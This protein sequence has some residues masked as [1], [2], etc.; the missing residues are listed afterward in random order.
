[1]RCLDDTTI[2]LLVEGRLASDAL[3][4]ID[5]HLDE[6]PSCR[7]KVAACARRSES[8]PASDLPSPE[9]TRSERHDLEP[10]S[11]PFV[12]RL[13]GGRYRVVKKLGGGGMGSVYEA[14]HVLIGRRVA[15]KLLHPQYASNRDVVRRFQNEARAAATLGHPNILEALD[16]GRT[17]DGLPFL[18]LELLEGH[19]LDHEIVERGAMPIDR[20]VIIALEIADALSAAHAAG[21]VHR[22]LK[23]ENVFLTNDG[24]VKVL[25]FGIS[26]I[27][28]SL[29]TGGLTAPGQMMGTPQYMAPEQ[30]EDASKADPRSDVYAL[31]VLLYR[32]LTGALPFSAPSL[33]QLLMKIVSTVPT[34]VAELRRDCPID[35]SDIVSR[36]MAS[37]AGARFASM[38][39]LARAIAPF[40]ATRS[41]IAPPSARGKER[42]VVTVLVASGV[43]DRDRA[44]SAI[45]AAGGRVEELSSGELLGLFGEETWQGDEVSR[46]LDAA[47]AVRG[48]TN[49]TAVSLGH[50]T[51]AG[52]APEGEPIDRALT[53]CDAGLAGVGLV[54][55]GREPRGAFVTRRVTS[56]LVEV[57]ARAAPAFSIFPTLH[58]ESQPLLGREAEVAQLRA[59]M[60]RV[61]EGRQ[62][63]IV[64]VSGPSGMGKTRLA[65]ELV[66]LV[67]PEGFSLLVARAR[68]GPAPRIG[69]FSGAI[70]SRAR[71][72]TRTANAPRIDADAPM[73]ERRRAVARLSAEASPE[74]SGELAQFL[75][76]LVGVPMPAST[77]LHAARG[78][79]RL[80]A[81]RLE[82]AIR[83][84]VGGLAAQAPLAIV[85]EDLQWADA[86]SLSLL[87]E[88]VDASWDL[89]ILVVGT[90]RD[91][92][93]PEPQALFARHD[94]TE[95]KLQGLRLPD[96]KALA[97]WIGGVEI[98]DALARALVERTSGTPFF[99]E[100][101]LDALVESAALGDPPDE[102]PLP[103]DVE[104]AVQARLDALDVE[105]KDVL[106]RA[107]VLGRVFS[108]EDLRVLGVED[109]ERRL[110]SLARR[111]FLR[112]RATR[113]RAG[114]TEY[115]MRTSLVADVVYR[116]LT[117]D[118]RRALHL[119]AARML[120]KQSTSEPEVVALHFERAGFADEAAK[121]FARAAL[122]AERRKDTDKVLRCAARALALGAP[123]EYRFALAM[124][125][126]DALE[127]E[128]RLDEQGPALEDAL[129]LARS[130][131]E[132]ARAL[133]AHGIH[134]L[135]TGAPA[136]A[137]PIFEEA[138]R[139]GST[140]GDPAAE[141][142]ALGRLATALVYAGRLDEARGTLA[143]AER[144]VMTRAPQLGAD[145][146]T[147]RAQLAGAEGDLGA[148]R[149]AYW[150][151]VELYTQAGD[152][153]SAAGAS[154]NLADAFNRVGAHAEAEQALREA[155]D[156]CR[157][158]R[159]G[160]MEG[161]GWLNLGYALTM[162]D[163]HGEAAEALGRAIDVAR[164]SKDARLG[165][166]AELYRARLFVRTGELDAAR[167]AALRTLDEATHLGIEAIAILARVI[168]ALAI[169]GLGDAPR[170]LALTTEA[171]RARGTLGGLE[172]DE[173]EL[174]A[175][176]VLALEANGRRDEAR[177]VREQGARLVRTAA[178]RIGDPAWRDR[179]LRDVPAHR[180]LL[181]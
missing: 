138:V 176:H 81:D 115:E 152:L 16:M 155:L 50:V 79:P 71:F 172:E 131:E 166:F 45:E 133:T 119:D 72:A 29:V 34:P 94:V 170:A 8:L 97:Q 24:R 106:K 99:L 61:V 104:A 130:P 18:V 69:L 107:S 132:R 175:A 149:S 57:S 2:D 168:A 55:F 15:L 68:P 159:V 58:A 66:R 157:R 181:G 41:S 161:Y 160:L 171:M 136:L 43:R 54:G 102:L 60:A 164:A 125:A 128:G 110:D 140:S 13:V 173:G 154:V 83:D 26:K 165:L 100:Q 87:E 120:A 114:A 17:E 1:M 74:D 143:N 129:A 53:A 103:I 48:V 3:P 14:E 75:G 96:V 88:I 65:A 117:D 40:R 6:C 169:L 9:P 22:D 31:G 137:I 10:M 148:R 49:A 33:P 89:P 144:L 158:L 5:L 121:A 67:E 142:R 162:L 77:P 127:A 92:L 27:T 116:L 112:R 108:S 147:W 179:F 98:S 59:T 44:T 20:A 151:A 19:D 124:A 7:R 82:L 167:D 134:V 113:E 91:D 73:D 180:Q 109:A 95:L 64:F 35:L 84:Y 177:A 178:Q 56:E 52:G 32:E 156:R 36:A 93:L 80:M 139:A 28:S 85:F 111:G 126:S 86:R 21:I 39:E 118:V 12:G 141:A 47:L 174:F 30:F 146:A 25:D 90:A 11:D 38:E 145:V 150:A 153:R 78:N 4:A 163:R 62:P 105:D 46:A 123:E 76:E 37:D 101:I 135:R 51:R 23:P 42:R 122:A 63:S 70:L